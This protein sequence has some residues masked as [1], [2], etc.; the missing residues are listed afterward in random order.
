MTNIHSRFLYLRILY[1]RITLCWIYN[2]VAV[3]LRL[4][5]WPIREESIVHYAQRLVRR[6]NTA[7]SLQTQHYWPVFIVNSYF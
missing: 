7:T 3:L 5:D 6:N 1:L 2:E 4:C